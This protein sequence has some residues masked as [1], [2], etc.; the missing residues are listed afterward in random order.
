MAVIALDRVGD[1][2]DGLI[3]RC[4]TAGIR[5][6]RVWILDPTDP[7]WVIPS[8]P[9]TAP[10][11]PF[12]VAEGFVDAVERHSASWGVEIDNSLRAVTRALV[13][14]GHSPLEIDAMFNI[15]EF[16][17]RITSQIEDAYLLGFFDQLERLSNEQRMQRYAAIANKLHRF[18]ADPRLRRMLC[19]TGT[20]PLRQIID[21]PEAVL[22]VPLRRDEL[23]G[24]A[25][26]LGDLII[27][28]IWNSALG[29][30][31]IPE[32]KRPLS[33]LILDEAQSF[34]KDN[35]EEIFT[36]SRRY[37][38]RLVIAHQSQAQL[39]PKLRDIIRNNAGYRAYFNVG[40]VDAREL[41]SE[42]FPLSKPEATQSVL[43]LGTGQAYALGR[44]KEAVRV[45]TP[46]SAAVDSAKTSEFRERALR[47]HAKP[48][49]EIDREMQ[50]RL[51]GFTSFQSVADHQAQEVRHVRKPRKS[52][53]P[54][55]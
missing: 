34:V 19:G 46:N 21:D 3:A 18:I 50:Q 26:L 24:G 16:R 22:L 4:A 32:G 51:K 36:Q 17:Q 38:L 40:P 27:Q 2:V 11:H 8:N 23:H 37:R 42:L 44:G 52:K 41:A 12:T 35:F 29:R 10:G 54:E 53:P 28:G 43:Q 33:T 5:P 13:L 31:K 25:D 7:D 47:C 30:S 15:S 20:L 1:L 9:F 48:C 49:I 45:V 6:E 14:T 55:W 39:D